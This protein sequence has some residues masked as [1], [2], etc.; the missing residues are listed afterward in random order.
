MN[1]DITNALKN[2]KITKIEIPKI[3]I[4]DCSEYTKSLL[5]PEYIDPE[6]VIYNVEEEHQHSPNFDS[7]YCKICNQSINGTYSWYYLCH[8]ENKE[9]SF[10]LCSLACLKKYYDKNPSGII[11]YEIIDYSRCSAYYKCKELDNLRDKCQQHENLTMVNILDKKIINFCESAQAGV[12]LS[13]Y[14]M[15]EILKD[16]SNQSQIHAKESNE[17]LKASASQNKQQFKESVKMLEKS[18]IESKKQFKITF[19][20]TILTI[21][22]TV[23]N[24]LVA[25][26][27]YKN[28]DVVNELKTLN[29]K[30]IDINRNLSTPKSQSKPVVN[31]DN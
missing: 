9:K 31:T 26:L 7:C 27:T 5:E 25:V 13:T 30:I 24:I 3:A 16:F 2:L 10:V 29:T 21:I 11:E 12:I 15:N 23:V 19:I 22:L 14:K 8:I 17:A 1:Y 28:N 6:K 4:P 18:G 20:M